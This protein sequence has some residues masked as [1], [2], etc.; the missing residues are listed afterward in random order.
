MIDT[1]TLFLYLSTHPKKQVLQS[2]RKEHPHTLQSIDITDDEH[3]HWF[4][5]YKYDIPVLH[6]N[7]FY[8][9]KH[10]LSKEV[11]IDALTIAQCGGFTMDQIGEPNADA[12]KRGKK[13]VA[14]EEEEKVTKD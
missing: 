7:N 13:S 9:T 10:R 1:R 2:I 8:W 5:K 11:A 14:E 3:A 12:M 6:I 4:A